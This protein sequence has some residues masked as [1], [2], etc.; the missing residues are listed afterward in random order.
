MRVEASSEV[1]ADQVRF[2]WL[3]T[4]SRSPPSMLLDFV[5]EK[6]RIPQEVSALE[7]RSRITES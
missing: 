7:E 1:S 5:P 2:I 6:Q 4:L 3:F